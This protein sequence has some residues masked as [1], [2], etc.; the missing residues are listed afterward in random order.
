M[1]RTFFRIC[2]MLILALAFSGCSA[3]S[4]FPTNTLEASLPPTWTG[5]A[6]TSE[7]AL[8]PQESP[9]PNPTAPISPTLEPAIEAS[10]TGSPTLEPTLQASRTGN[11]GLTPTIKASGTGIRPAGTTGPLCDDSQF[12]ED[13]TIPDGMVLK[14]GEEF[15]KT[16]K[17]KNTGICEWTTAYAIGYAYGEKM[18]G[19]ETKLLNSVAPGASV[20]IT[21]KFTA[22][23]FNYWYGSWWRLKN[24]HGDYFGDFVFVSV[25]VAEGTPYPTATPG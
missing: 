18:H 22:P 19:S 9:S 3:D 7:A 2:C 5:N 16:W 17:I 23:L 24:E 1:S 12:L 6:P 8:T 21:I 15:K 14:P 25:I 20:D 13:V 4:G 10:D 11:P